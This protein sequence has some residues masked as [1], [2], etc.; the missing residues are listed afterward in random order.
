LYP[1]R[2]VEFLFAFYKIADHV[3]HQDTGII[4]GKI[5]MGEIVDSD[6]L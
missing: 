6:K 1:L 2:V 3:A 5:C 4:K